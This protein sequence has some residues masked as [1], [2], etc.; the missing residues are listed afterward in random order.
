MVKSGYGMEMDDATSLVFDDLDERQPYL[1]IE[2]LLGKTVESGEIAAGVDRDASPE[3]V[4]QS[5]G[6]RALKRNAR[7]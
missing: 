2:R 7:S 5:S 4:I 3:C 1:P 6:A